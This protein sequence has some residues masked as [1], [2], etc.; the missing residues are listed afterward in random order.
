[1]NSNQEKGLT[2]SLVENVDSPGLLLPEAVDELL[3]TTQPTHK[4]HPLPS[5]RLKIVQAESCTLTSH[6]R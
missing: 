6:F 3:N 4:I 5:E 1:M 2:A